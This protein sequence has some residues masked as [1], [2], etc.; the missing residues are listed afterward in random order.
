[1]V[2]LFLG[3]IH[4]VLFTQTHKGASFQGVL[5]F[6]GASSRE[7]PTGSA[8]QLVLHWGHCF[9]LPPVNGV[10]EGGNVNFGLENGARAVSLALNESIE[11]DPNLISG[12]ISKTILS[13]VE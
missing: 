7:C 8:S 10:R 4:Q 11:A 13:Q 1:M 12:K 5:S 9:V 6:Q 2:A 3:A